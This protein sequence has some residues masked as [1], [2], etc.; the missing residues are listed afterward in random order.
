M[1][2]GEYFT[3]YSSQYNTQFYSLCL[4]LQLSAVGAANTQKLTRLSILHGQPK[5]NISAGPSKWSRRL[6]SYQQTTVRTSR[7]TIWPIGNTGHHFNQ[8]L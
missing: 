7:L 5:S 2:L 8:T 1:L 4:Y 3:H 6:H